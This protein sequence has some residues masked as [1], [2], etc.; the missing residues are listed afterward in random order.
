MDLGR[1][2]TAFVPADTPVEVDYITGRLVDYAAIHGRYG[3]LEGVLS[4]DKAADAPTE[5][6]A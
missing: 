3:K 1:R 4:L 2:V 6:S 5:G